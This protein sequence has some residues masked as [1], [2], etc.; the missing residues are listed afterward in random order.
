[1]TRSGVARQINFLGATV[2]AVN[3]SRVVVQVAADVDKF[4]ADGREFG[5]FGTGSLRENGVAGVAVVGLDGELPVG[6]LVLAVVT[7]ET[8]RRTA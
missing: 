2:V 6:S 5:E 4:L 7:A 3:A 8:A 1:M